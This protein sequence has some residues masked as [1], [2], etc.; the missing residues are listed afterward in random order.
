M[1]KYVVMK[2][3]H[4]CKCLLTTCV[5]RTTTVTCKINV[6]GQKGQLYRGWHLMGKY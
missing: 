6:Q 3:G 5:D 2:T 1:S 4:I